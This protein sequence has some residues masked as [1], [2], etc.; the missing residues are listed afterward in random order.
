DDPEDLDLLVG[1]EPDPVLDL[2][3][4]LELAVAGQKVHVAA[5]GRVE[6]RR[7]AGRRER[8]AGEA[9]LLLRRCGRILAMRQDC[10]ERAAALEPA[11]VRRDGKQVLR[12]PVVD[13]A[14]DPGALLGDRAAELG[15]ADRAPDAD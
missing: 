13:L 1:R 11:R 9:R 10:R 15:E 8:E 4:D 6:W 5:E 3:V 12:E 2:E 14:R 7:A